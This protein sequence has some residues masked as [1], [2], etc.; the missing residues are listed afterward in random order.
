MRFYKL[1]RSLRAKLIIFLL[2]AIAV[3]LTAS[4]IITNVRTSAIV[5]DDKVKTASNLL[6]QGKTNLQHYLSTVTQ[7]SLLVYNGASSGGDTL[8]RI[9]E[10]GRQ[11][12]LSEQ[13]VYKSLQAI[14][15]AVREVHQVYLHAD[16]GQRGY[17]VVEGNTKKDNQPN[18]A[19]ADKLRNAKVAAI[20]EPTH[21]SGNY[22]IN[23]PPYYTP[24]RVVSL[25]RNI[26]RIP[27]DEQI[28]TLAIDIN[29]S[30]IDVICHELYDSSQEQLYLL[31][32]DGIVVYGPQ[33]EAIGKL[34][35]DSEGRA[36]VSA[37]NGS[38]YKV[39]N[40]DGFNGVY[41][42]D[43][44]D[45]GGIHWTLVKKIPN[46]TLQAGTRQVTMVNTIVLVVSAIIV[47][48][49]AI[50]VSFWITWPI[51]QLT[52]YVNRIQS[53]ELDI[54]IRL[55][56][57]DEIGVLA[58]RFRLMMETINNLVLRE[59][60]LEIANKT[61]QLKALQSQV[62]PHFLYNA[63]QMIGTAALQSGAPSVYQLV[64]LLGKLMRYSMSGSDKRVTLSQEID[65]TTAYLELQKHRFGDK[66][67]YV[68]ETEPGMAMLPVPRM[69]LQPLAENVF[70]H[71]FDPAGGFMHVRIS[72]H[73]RDE[74]VIIS[75]EDDGTPL[76]DE[77]LE[78]LRSLVEQQGAGDQEHIGLANVRS[79]LK[80]NC[81]EQADLMLDHGARGGLRVTLIVPISYEE[82]VNL[83]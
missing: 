5:T 64:M 79:R 65:H 71:A 12:Y 10:Q 80:L 60:K 53:G 26:L 4:I 11:D 13:E 76:A 3:P 50:Y 38:G 40:T 37:R 47:I 46:S 57:T 62:Q 22:G 24:R 39:A 75:I 36:I 77:R 67:D 74:L 54:D 78:E 51:R 44:L 35:N 43:H 6:Y 52:G 14:A 49:M 2:L 17:L 16:K 45:E 30:V 48:A 9:L 41:V 69:I 59:Y 7:A 19:N 21:D 42:Y 73:K 27:S 28:G 1:R 61:N 34:W 66:L 55:N 18:P 15:L 31:S 82:G 58:R 83:L 56:R 68:I 8:Y 20:Y 33:L 72:A 32:D 63:L 29:T 81:G 70:K 25:H 23:K